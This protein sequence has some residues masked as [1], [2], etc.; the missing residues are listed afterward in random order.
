MLAEYGSEA[1]LLAGGTGLINLMKVGMARPGRLL[2]LHA[3]RDMDGVAL[4]EGGLQLG[5]MTRLL[6]IERHPAVSHLW[7]VLNSA[8]RDLASP[9]VRSMATI[10]GAIAHGDPN[11]DLP[12]VLIA[13]DAVLHV[14]THDGERQVPLAGFYRDFYETTLA[15]T[16]MICG[17]RL[18]RP[19]A[20]S[21]AVFIKFLPRS[22][23]DYA[24][25]S[26]C[27]RIDFEAGSGIVRDARVVLG[28]VGSTILRATAAERALTGVLPGSATIAAA[29]A[30]AAA[31]TDPLSDTRGSA[32]YK[33]QMTQVCVRR[34]LTQLLAS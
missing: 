8:L 20:G 26:V 13:L 10:G 1:R 9:R 33:R 18:P 22:A 30:L 6:D 27:C 31:A 12:A 15:P 2:S 34:A 32:S 4:D 14:A 7:P 24:T 28:G 29:A 21:R 23:E 11:Q 3:L 25:V 17:V 5:A 19:A 16:E